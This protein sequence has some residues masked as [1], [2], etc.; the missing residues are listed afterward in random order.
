MI[1]V[2]LGVKRNNQ[3]IIATKFRLK[4]FHPL[5]KQYFVPLFQHNNFLLLHCSTPK[6]G[7]TLTWKIRFFFFYH[8]SPVQ[9]TWKLCI[10]NNQRLGI[11]GEFQD[12]D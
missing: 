4:N 1:V 6:M 3:V 12:S 7:I 11:E 5:K 8:S 9:L 2:Y 10:G